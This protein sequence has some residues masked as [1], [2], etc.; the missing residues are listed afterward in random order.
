MKNQNLFLILCILLS[1]SSLSI[2]FGGC[3]PD[4][5]SP[6]SNNL[7]C[8]I[9]NP[10]QDLLWLKDYIEQRSKDTSCR[11]RV[12]YYIYAENDVFLVDDCHSTEVSD[13]LT[14]VKDCE[15]NVICEFGGIAGLNTCPDF[16]TEAIEK[17]I[18]WDFAP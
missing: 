15:G 11:A 7:I 10:T 13:H 3:T 2:F 5:P 12:T 6:E 16:E 18:L 17:S 4:D 8:N 14:F 1:F 9:R